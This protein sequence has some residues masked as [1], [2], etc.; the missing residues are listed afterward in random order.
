MRPCWTHRHRC[1]QGRVLRPVK[2]DID[3]VQGRDR[4]IA[5]DVSRLH[6][7]HLM[8]IVCFSW[9]QKGVSLL[10][11]ASDVSFP[12]LNHHTIPFDNMFDCCQARGLIFRMTE[13]MHPKLYFLSSN[14]T[15]LCIFGF[16]F[17]QRLS[18]IYYEL[19][20]LRICFSM[21][22]LWCSGFIPE[23]LL[24]T[25]FIGIVVPSNP[26]SQAF[27]LD[28]PTLSQIFEGRSPI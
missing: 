5:L 26:L 25:A 4:T 14:A 2:R 28:L 8:D 12:L 18:H 1:Q 17:H 15:I 6:K 16:S 3:Q 24:F 9:I 20:H 13:L 21:N 27:T 11:F 19:F 10:I 22:I 7:V 23:P